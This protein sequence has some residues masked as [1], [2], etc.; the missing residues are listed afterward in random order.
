MQTNKKRW[1][2]PLMA[3]IFMSSAVLPMCTTYADSLDA[4]VEI[5][6]NVEKYDYSAQYDETPADEW[7][8][9]PAGNGSKDIYMY[10]KGKEDSRKLKY[11]WLFDD[12]KYSYYMD[13]QNVHW[14]SVPYYDKEKMVDAWIRL[15]PK[16]YEDSILYD[17]EG[18]PSQ[19]YYLEHYYI[20]PSR[21]QVQFLCELEVTGRPTNAIS[22]RTYS[23]QNWEN[24]VPG[25]IEDTIYH[26]VLQSMKKY[27]VGGKASKFSTREFL[28]EYLRIGIW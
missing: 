7:F 5:E 9:A 3:A 10:R 25:S 19:R 24:L 27:R 1:L 28:N 26:S 16:G 11:I 13:A 20:R 4:P 6:D 18:N 17:A 8:A 14:V 2:Y 22:E 23:S 12:E 21:Q 15:Q